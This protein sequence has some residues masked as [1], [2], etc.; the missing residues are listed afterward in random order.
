[1]TGAPVP[2]GLDSV[3]RVEDTDAESE[4]PGRVR[5]LQDR[6]RE[7]NVR[8]AGEDM[9]AGDPVLAAGEIVTP[10]RVALL[11]A[12]GNDPVSVVA[13]PRVVLLPTGDELRPAGDFDEVRAGDAIP[14]SNGPTLAAAC[15]AIAVPPTLLPPVP[16]DA[17]ALA[18][19]VSRA[20][21]DGDVLLTL[22]GA[23]MGTADLVKDVLRGFDFELDFWR[24][25]MRPGSPFSFGRIPR[26]GRRSLAVF[27]LPGN[28]ASAFVTFQVLVRPYLLAVAGHREIHRPVVDAIA[29]EPMKTHAE[30][31]LFHRVVLEFDATG[32]LHATLAGAQGS[33]LVSS[34]GRAQGLAYVPPG[35]DCPA[36][37]PLRVLLLDDGPAGA[38]E[39]GY[40][41]MPA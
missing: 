29:A 35:P 9:L 12:T 27:G 18:T 32:G 36:G 22:G 5:I 37:S 17:D 19:A 33:G 24:V 13:R 25:K 26:E 38:L 3:V 31:A 34:L 1:M 20:I 15:R 8:R 40:T 4:A 14:E 28:P 2:R 11:A 10:G 7:R 41:E 30:R 16:D 21:E 39:P 23:S 6:D